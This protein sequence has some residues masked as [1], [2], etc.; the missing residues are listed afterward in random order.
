MVLAVISDIHGNLEA[1]EAVL[2]DIKGSNISEVYNLGDTVGYGPDP[3]ACIELVRS[4][5]SV[6]GNH[7]EMSVQG[8]KE[9]M[10]PNW[11]AK[12]SLIWTGQQ[13]SQEEKDY[14]SS[15]P[16]TLKIGDK[17]VLAHANLID[18]P[19]FKYL[20]A[21]EAGFS[22]TPAYETMNVLELLNCHVAF[23]G[24]SHEPRYWEKYYTGDVQSRFFDKYKKNQFCLNPQIFPRVI[25]NVGSVGQ[26]RDR[27][28]DACWV[29]VNE[30]QITLHRV[31]YDCKPTQEKMR[32]RCGLSSGASDALTNRLELGK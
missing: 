19:G 2:A 3:K 27:N 24:H 5:P 16:Y 7:D 11:V 14:L 26:P 29:E 1:L 12:E 23:V 28:P 25:V 17:F 31:S 15:L 18:P 4:F 9:D 22:K 6:K 21:N 20:T 8:F 30:A 32:S 13:L 10:M